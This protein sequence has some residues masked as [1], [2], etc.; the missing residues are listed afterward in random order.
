MGIRSAI[1]DQLVRSCRGRAWDIELERLHTP[2]LMEQECFCPARLHNFTAILGRNIGGPSPK[3]N[4]IALVYSD[5][6][7]LNFLFFTILSKF[8]FGHK[9]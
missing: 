8:S 4:A 9:Q 2:F 1:G 5:Q 3:C 6:F 7:C